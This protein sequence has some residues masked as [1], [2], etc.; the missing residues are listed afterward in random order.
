MYSLVLVSADG[1]ER[2][3]QLYWSIGIEDDSLPI[4]RLDEFEDKDN[5]EDYDNNERGTATTLVINAAV[6][7][8]AWL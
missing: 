5:K 3:F 1:A 6:T 8:T 4:D 2:R 7:R